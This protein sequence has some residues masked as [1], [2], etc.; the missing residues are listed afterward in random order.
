VDNSVINK[1]TAM[2]A[3]LAAAAGI[4]AYKGAQPAVV[5]PPPVPI[6]E[7]CVIRFY[8]GM[9]DV[10]PHQPTNHVYQLQTSANLTNWVAVTNW[11]SDGMFREVWVASA[12]SAQFFRVQNLAR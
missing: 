7:I 4:F 12:S 11:N 9:D 1:L 8:C 6:T 5:P 3:G 10:L 2:T